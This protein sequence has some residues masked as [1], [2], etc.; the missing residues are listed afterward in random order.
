MCQKMRMR[1]DPTG[2][3]YSAPPDSLVG[4][5][6]PTSKGR[7]GMGG[8]KRR[9]KGRGRE[10]KEAGGERGREGKAYRYLFFPTSSPDRDGSPAS[11]RA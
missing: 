4:F 9:G 10:R 7:E 3:A 8:E 11:S 6:G 2:G 1:P 5:K